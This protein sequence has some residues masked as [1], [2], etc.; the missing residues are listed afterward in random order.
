MMYSRF[1]ILLVEDNSADVC[2]TREALVSGKIQHELYVARDGEEAM[3]YLRL[4]GTFQKAPRPDLIL[5]DLNLPRKD[6]LEVLAE[7]K[8][9]PELMSIPVIILTSSQAEE[10]ILKSYDLHAN[11]YIVKPV[12]V[13]RFFKV[14]G[15]IKEFWM[16]IVRLPP[17]VPK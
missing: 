7:I 16:S 11:G 6:G 14:I 8:A 13:E 2:L 3:A 12:D 15:Q 10:D 5:L 9:D 4:L 17:N 1:V